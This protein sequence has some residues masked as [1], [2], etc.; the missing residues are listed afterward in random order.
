MAKQ[1]NADPL[2]VA[3]NRRFLQTRHLHAAA[4]HSKMFPC[5]QLVL[6]RTKEHNMTNAFFQRD[7]GTLVSIAQ[8]LHGCAALKSSVGLTAC[9]SGPHSSRLWSLA[10]DPTLAIAVVE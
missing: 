9:L 10:V 3:G 7:V 2:C 5:T 6:H 8:F 4:F 1:A